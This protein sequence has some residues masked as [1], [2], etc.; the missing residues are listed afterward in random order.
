MPEVQFILHE[1]VAMPPTCQIK[2]GLGQE[3]QKNWAGDDP[4]GTARRRRP[5]AILE[6]DFIGS[7]DDG[8][9]LLWLI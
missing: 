5:E 3:E 1:K 2:Q 6:E 4:V 9:C 7:D 8:V